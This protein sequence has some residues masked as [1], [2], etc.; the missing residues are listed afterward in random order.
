MALALQNKRLV[1]AYVLILLVSACALPASSLEETA[2]LGRTPFINPRD[3][4]AYAQLNSSSAAAFELGHEVFNTHWVAAGTVG[5]TRRDG[6]GPLFN[7]A[8]CDACHNE[9]ARGRG[10]LGDG[11]VPAQL[12]IQLGQRP[13]DTSA[14]DI[15][16]AHYGHV[17]NTAAIDGLLPEATARLQYTERVGHYS[18]G[19]QWTLRV[20]HYQ[21]DNLRYGPLAADTVIKPRISPPLFGVGLL[22]AVPVQALQA[23]GHA[24]AIGRFGWQGNSTSIRDQTT[25]AFAREMGLTSAEIPHDDCTTVQ[26]DCLTQASGGTPEVSEELL[27]A[28][29]EF[30]NWL[31]VPVATSGA[32]LDQPQ[33]QMF[34]HLG[35]EDCHRATLPVALAHA[36]ASAVIHPFTDL[37]LHDMGPALADVDAAG[38][39]VPSKWRTPPLWGLGYNTRTDDSLVYL[40][41]GRARSIEEAILW[42]DG[43]AQAARERFMRLSKPQRRSLLEYLQSL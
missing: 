16:D 31:A 36:Q 41:D 29:I 8:A 32:H 5:A 12:V 11:P 24:N 9:G 21:I 17:L 20:P 35:C 33:L 39:R 30:Q 14:A 15:G 25:K 27:S 23:R 3:P 28:L 6:V 38:N 19:A 22:E 10:P 4:P 37:R 1:A 42:H 2:Q 18:D 34:K 43:E 7:A 13:L 40:H 26:A